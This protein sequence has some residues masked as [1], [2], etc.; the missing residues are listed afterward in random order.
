M[1]QYY[2][3]S[4]EGF[5]EKIENIPYS[6]SI[7]LKSDLMEKR[8]HEVNK[9]SALELIDF[10]S[11]TEGIVLAGH[12]EHDTGEEFEDKKTIR[13]EATFQNNTDKST[14][15]Y[16]TMNFYDEDE[17]SVGEDRVYESPRVRVGKGWKMTKEPLIDKRAVKYDMEVEIG[18]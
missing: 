1:P 8:K 10:T 16:V 12:E 9:E 5:K 17:N 13:I 15:F 18:Y 14:S 7:A 3:I 11:D 2:I 4:Q 6:N